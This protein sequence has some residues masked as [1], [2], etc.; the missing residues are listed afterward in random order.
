MPERSKV[1]SVVVTLNGLPWLPRC[2]DSLGSTPTVVVDHGSTDGTVELVRGSHPNVLLVEQG[3]LGMGAGNNAGMRALDAEYWF[4]INS[5]AWV[6]HGALE[7]LVA[8]ADAHPHA[9][10][11]GPRLVDRKS[12]RLNSSHIPLSRMPSSA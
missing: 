12:T 11:I 3:N 9:A 7:E 4:L 1:A 8:F 6:E 5:D 10:V 2:L